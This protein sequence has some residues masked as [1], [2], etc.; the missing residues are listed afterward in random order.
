MK[1]NRILS[2]ILALV[3]ITA[4][5]LV[6]V[7]AAYTPGGIIWYSVE[8]VATSQTNLN[9][10]DPVHGLEIMNASAVGATFTVGI[11]I[12]NASQAWFPD[13]VGGVE[14]HFDFNISGFLSYAI[15]V[16]FT[17]YVGKPGGVGNGSV[18]TVTAGGLYDANGAAAVPS[19]GVYPTAVSYDE[20]VAWGQPWSDTGVGNLVATITFEILNNIPVQPAANVLL[21]LY[22]NTT[23]CDMTDYTTTGSINFDIKQGTF[24]LDATPRTPPPE[25]PEPNLFV[26]PP[27]IT[28]G[29][30]GTD[31]TV[32][33]DINTTIYWD[34]A[35][36]DV[37]FTYNATQLQLV[38]CQV[39]GFLAQN[40]GTPFGWFYNNTAGS[41][42]GIFT[43]TV[44]GPGL[45][46]STS[47]SIDE[48]WSLFDMTF[49]CLTNSTTPPSSSV[50]GIPAYDLASW[51]HPERWYPPWN[52]VITA[53]D[54]TS[55][56]PSVITNGAY[57]MLYAPLGALIDSYTQYPAPYGG[58]GAGQHSDSFAPQQEVCLYGKVTFA[59]YP[60]SNKLVTFEIDNALGQKLTILQNVTDLNGIAE[61]CFRIPMPSGINGTD[62]STIG[63]WH[64]TETV[65]IDQVIVNDTVW[66]QVGY[67]FNF[68]NVWAN[69]Q[70]YD[71]FHTP[72][73]DLTGLI[74]TIHEQPLNV[75]VSMDT[76]DLD[77][78]PIGEFAQMYIGLTA[79]RNNV[80]GP[81]GTTGGY[82]VVGN[83]TGNAAGLVSTLS[84]L[85][86][87]A[88]QLPPT[89][90][91]FAV[92]TWA[93]VGLGTVAGYV[94][95]DFPRNGGTA[96]GL[97]A[98]NTFS[99]V[100]TGP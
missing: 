82:Y 27:S 91:Q 36:F 73:F 38:N 11:H 74:Q 76:Y 33:V 1:P 21:P 5:I 75:L 90:V 96:W 85:T 99:I 84:A 28:G 70:P 56:S 71:Q 20:I 45:E 39:G 42:E 80:N 6:A 49:M 67:M 87:A 48:T 57:T 30:V 97:P 92:P 65:E 62:P 63:W 64:E 61:V 13:G 47:G 95:T 17:D 2:L 22:L 19:G 8:P 29:A 88:T 26:Y 9:V 41:V 25:A 12:E 60:V 58:Q 31:I 15:P 24:Q 79:T 68:L 10:I 53:V 98:Y 34:V 59:G 23:S 72:K 44:D 16:A 37:N 4:P 81:G 66:F 14:V 46:S 7:H 77:G 55:Y 43:K 83:M 32:S 40:G 89:D 51:A 93:R 78:N 86:P 69:N 54:I 100:Y 94:L 52:S 3:L 18:S 35:G 50:L